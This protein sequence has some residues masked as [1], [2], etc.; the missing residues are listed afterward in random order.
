MNDAEIQDIYKASIEDYLSD[1]WIRILA[2]NA[3]RVESCG[4]LRW[5]RIEETIE[6]AKRCG[7][8]KLGMAFCIG[9]R[10]EAKILA[11]ILER[12]GFEVFSVMCKTG[13]I[14]K[15]EIGLRKEE[16]IRPEEFEAICNPVA[17]AKILNTAATDFNLILGLCVGHDTLF[18]M[19]SKAPVTCIA[20]KDRVLAHNPLGAIYA[21]HYLRRRLYGGNREVDREVNYETNLETNQTNLED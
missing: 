14:A 10:D 21:K 7:F 19:H 20:V 9:L 12:H 11:D 13:S 16:K 15:E 2:L 1:D 4:Y 3:A 17:Q 18:I 5:T 6:F 8:K